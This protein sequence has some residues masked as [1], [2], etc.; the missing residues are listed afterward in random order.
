MNK[1]MN[2]INNLKDAIH[3]ISKSLINLASQLEMS[4]PN[5]F[6]QAGQSDR[7]HFLALERKSHDMFANLEGRS[8]EFMR[9]SW[10]YGDSIHVD[11]EYF[12]FLHN[13]IDLEDGDY[14]LTCDIY[15]EGQSESTALGLVNKISVHRNHIDVRSVSR[16]IR[17]VNE[18]ELNHGGNAHPYFE[19]LVLQET[20]ELY[21]ELGS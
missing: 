1:I 8:D 10:S 7:E 3:K 15:I 21:L 20:G 14:A 9:T 2:E 6:K 5:V 4:P 19:D 16:A 13:Y 18:Q 11:G 17:E 12:T